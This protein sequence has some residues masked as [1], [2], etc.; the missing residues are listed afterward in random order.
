MLLYSENSIV[1]HLA[2]PDLPFNHA[3]ISGYQIQYSFDI[4]GC[5]SIQQVCFFGSL[6][7]RKLAAEVYGAHEPGGEFEEHEGGWHFVND[8][9]FADSDDS[10]DDDMSQHSSDDSLMSDGL[11][12]YSSLSDES[13]SNDDYDD[14]DHSVGTSEFATSEDDSGSSSQEDSSGG[15][16]EDGEGL[17]EDVQPQYQELEGLAE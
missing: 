2:S 13:G 8:G 5:S 3:V 17:E 10:A 9:D 1:L 11:E 14:D 4:A 12:G 16:D 15:S 7:V 6:Q